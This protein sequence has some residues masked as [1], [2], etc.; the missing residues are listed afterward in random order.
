MANDYYEVKVKKYNEN[1]YQVK[2]YDYHIIT[3]EKE[4]NENNDI[5][6]KSLHDRL[7][8]AKRSILSSQNRAKSKIYDYLRSNTWDLFVTLTFDPKKVDSFDYEQ[9]Q[10]RVS[11]WLNNLKSRYCKDLQYL[12]VPE[13]HKS[14]RYHFHGVFKNIEGL[15]L[16]YSGKQDTD[17]TPIYNIDCYTYGFTTATYIKS[18]EKVCSYVA[19]YITKELS[20]HLKGKKHYWVSRGL[21]LPEEKTMTRLELSYNGIT[22][23]ILENESTFSKCETKNIDYLEKNIYI[24]EI[25][26]RLVSDI[27]LIQSLF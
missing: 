14:G 12:I 19:K 1:R 15:D 25:D 4:K 26:K 11:K 21:A 13:L 24:Y 18:H 5:S 23:K 6:E 2:V 10:N 20:G 16:V 22:K 3:K 7:S 9:C 8:D 27:S 17:G